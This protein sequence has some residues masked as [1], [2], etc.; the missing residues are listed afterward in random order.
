M[1]VEGGPEP[2]S[3]MGKFEL[4]KRPEVDQ[5]VTRL[6]S[7]GRK[8][9]ETKQGRIS[10]HFGFIEKALRM[11]RG[12]FVADVKSDLT[13]E[14]TIN[15]QNEDGSEDTE[16]IDLLVQGLFDS[17]K[18]ILRRRG[19]GEELEE[20]G[21][22]PKPEDYE[23]F[24]Q[25]IYDKK[26]EQEKTLGN[27]IDYLGSEE[28]DYYPVWFKYLAI[29][30]LQ[31]MGKR[32]RDIG[33]YS[34]RSANTLQPFPDL[35]R[36]SFSRT[37]DAIKKMQSEKTLLDFEKIN[38]YSDDEL[39]ALAELDRAAAKGDFAKLYANF[40]NEIERERRERGESTAGQWR[41]FPQGSNP[42]ALVS[43]LEGKGT[44]WCTAGLSVAQDQ[45]Q[46]GEFYIY[47]TYDKDRKPTDPRVAIFLVNGQISEVRGVYGKDQD[48]E[49]DFVDIAREKYKDFSGSERYEKKDR[50]MKFLSTVEKKMNASESLSKGELVF[51][52]EIDSPIEGFGHGADPRVAEL[53]SQRDPKVDA[54]IVLECQ[55]DEIA[56]GQDQIGENTRSYI[57]PLFPDIFK[58]QNLENIYASFPEGKIR[59]SDLGIGGKTKNELVNELKAN[60]IKIY[61]YAQDMLDSSE[62]TT[63]PSPEQINL[64]RLKV[65]DLGFPNGATTDRIYAKAEELGLELCPAEVG[66]HQRLKDI[67]QPL[68]EWYR[69]AMKQITDRRGDP[70]VF[71][72]AHND[73]GLWLD[74]YFAYPAYEWSADGGFVFRL[75]NVSQAA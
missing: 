2:E 41:H 44:E 72:L 43:T 33:D 37:L 47:Y 17:E 73:D 42:E 57:G 61:E 53:R 32:D 66:P 46:S 45:L 71:D 55:P 27:W 23:K 4:H 5:S 50:D 74:S 22:T 14:F 29:R 9:E 25:Q 54:P 69:I 60:G 8:V 24:R 56:W 10:A 28:A 31:K 49:L 16:R 58:L 38:D 70:K 39:S 67:D 20:Y 26:A 59:K 15:L 75:R 35:S 7:H 68:G 6:R 11:D 21:D 18:D 13:R 40:Q 62:F 64:V 12:H 36:E 3:V 1:S 52:Y 65:R 51:L 30:S 63:Q 34:K 48:L 19:M